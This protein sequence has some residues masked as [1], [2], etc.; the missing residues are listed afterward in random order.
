MLLS[1]NTYQVSIK[2]AQVLQKDKTVYIYETI[3]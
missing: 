3:N 2:M 1:K